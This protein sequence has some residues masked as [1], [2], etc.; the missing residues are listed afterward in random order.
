MPAGAA[1][2]AWV[3]Q[4]RVV[5]R[6]SPSSRFDRRPGRWPGRGRGG[7]RARAPRGGP[8]TAGEVQQPR[9][10]PATRS[11]A[12]GSPTSVVDELRRAPRR[13][14]APRPPAAPR[15]ITLRGRARAARGRPAEP[16]NPGRAGDEQ[17][18]RES[19]LARSRS[20]TA[21]FQA[22]WRRARE[23]LAPGQRGGP[24]RRSPCPRRRCPRRG[25]A[26]RG[27]SGRPSSTC[28]T[29][30]VTARVV[31]RSAARPAATSRRNFSTTGELLVDHRGW[32]RGRC[33]G[34]AGAR[35]KAVAARVTG[36]RHSS[37]VI[38][39]RWGEIAP[40]RRTGRRC[41]PRRSARPP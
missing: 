19:R 26:L 8:G 31:R 9:R 32:V 15:R 24:G 29:P 1:G 13:G 14:R 23:V 27:G 6:R 10:R 28:T 36:A 21:Y 2:G 22:G 38:F 33:P 18:S 30:I 3:D 40:A 17:S 4:A 12:A 7:G 20:S 34:A 5:A 35:S 39:V 16:R 41:R 11:C 25:R 37:G